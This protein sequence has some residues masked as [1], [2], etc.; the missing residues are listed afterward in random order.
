[1][2]IEL[3]R[4]DEAVELLLL[5]E[6]AD[7]SDIRD[8]RHWIRVYSNLVELAG[9]FPAQ[10]AGAPALSRRLSSWEARL[11]FWQR[12]AREIAQRQ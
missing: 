7:V 1:M 5:D 12:R 9:E 3:P 10:E 8:V 4:H 11:D 2:I 6:P